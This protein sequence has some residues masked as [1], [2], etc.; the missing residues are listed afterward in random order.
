[1]SNEETVNINDI[2]ELMVACKNESEYFFKR[3][4][5]HYNVDIYKYDGQ[6]LRRLIIQYNECFNHRGSNFHVDAMRR[7]DP[8]RIKMLICDNERLIKGKIRKLSK[9]AFHIRNFT[10]NV[11]KMMYEISLTQKRN[12]I[13]LYEIDVWGVMR[14]DCV[15]LETYD[16]FQRRWAVESNISSGTSNEDIVI[17]RSIISETK[18]HAKRFDSN[19]TMEEC[20]NFNIIEYEIQRRSLIFSGD[21]ILGNEVNDEE[22]EGMLGEV[23]DIEK[24][25]KDLEEKKRLF[26]EVFESDNKD[27]KKSKV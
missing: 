18:I 14:S 22:L 24:F 3:K 12:E 27:S 19:Y 4:G 9:N 13:L 15:R 1:M 23:I 16:Y 17:E 11:C 25:E 6:E 2:Y 7:L 26:H 8:L 10:D 21:V 5:I 20:D